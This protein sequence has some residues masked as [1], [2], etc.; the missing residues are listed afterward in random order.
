MHYVTLVV[1]NKNCNQNPAGKQDDHR[2]W[3]DERK[4]F[5]D[6]RNVPKDSKYIRKLYRLVY[7]C[8]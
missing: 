3:L 4:K 1:R 5:F 6:D 2:V 7:K 8:M